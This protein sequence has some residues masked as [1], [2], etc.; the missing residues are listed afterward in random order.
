MRYVCSLLS[1]FLIANSVAQDVATDPPGT[2]LIED[3]S[4]FVETTFD[5]NSRTPHPTLTASGGTVTSFANAKE[6]GD[7]SQKVTVSAEIPKAGWYQV[8]MRWTTFLNTVAQ[9]ATNVPVTI[10][11]K[12]GPFDF[13][14]N[15]QS[16]NKWALLGTYEFAAGTQPVISFSN[17][18]TLQGANWDAV[19]LIP[20]D[21][22]PSPR[23]A[24]EL[25]KT[26]DGFGR[27]KENIKAFQIAQLFGR[28]DQET[29]PDAVQMAARNE[30]RARLFWD[31]MLDTPTEK[32]N[33]NWMQTSNSASA[34]R[35][36]EA[37]LLREMAVAYVGASNHLGMDLRGNPE[38]L[39]AIIRG[40]E[41]FSKRYNVETKWDVNWWDYEI[42]VPLNLLPAL[43]VLGDAVPTDLRDGFI[44]AS[45]RF[46]SDPRK[47]YNNA[48]PATGAN[49]LWLCNVA[50][51]RGALAEDAGLLELVKESVLEP[52]EFVVRDFDQK[53]K[54][55]SDGFYEDGSFIQ[56][57]G[58][59]YAAA[60]GYLLLES[61]AEVAEGLQNTPWALTGPATENAFR[62]MEICFDPFVVRGETVQ[63][64]VGR[65]LG[66]PN[67]EGNAN[68]ANF[69][70]TA[71]KLLPFANPEQAARLRSLIKKWV[72]E[73]KDGALLEYARTK[74]D[75]ANPVSA[76]VLA[77][78]VK[79]PAIK[80]LPPG[81]G[82]Q[83]FANMDIATHRTG[84]FA[85]SLGMNS[86]RTQ[87][88][89][90]IWGANAKGWFQSE[91]LFLLYSPDIERYRD[92]YFNLVDPYRFP[93]V[94]VE[95]FERKPGDGGG[96]NPGKPGGGDFVGGVG[97]NGNGIAAMHLK[98][99]EGALEARRAWFFFGDQIICLGA[100]IG[101]ASENLI[102]TTIENARLISE[103]QQLVI[104]SQ[105]VAEGPAKIWPGA[106]WA[107]L[108]GSR[109]GADLGWVFLDGNPPLHSLIETRNGSR[110]DTHIKTGD[111]TPRS[112]RFATLWLDHGKGQN[113]SG[114]A[115]VVLPGRTQQQLQAYA[116]KP[117][118]SILSNTASAQSV[119]DPAL[120]LTGIVAWSPGEIS[121]VSLDQP[122]LVLIQD[123]GKE[124]SVAVS[125]PTMRLKDPVTIK[126]PHRV[127]SAT[128]TD[129]RIKVVSLAPLTLEFQPDGANG[130]THRVS[131][132]K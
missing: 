1:F 66:S 27:L 44:A 111:P 97:L 4:T 132:S 40:L 92:A 99:A 85:V 109:P 70:V 56:H 14:I 125:D 67:Y 94:T 79:D 2:I 98:P 71:S 64:V 108:G 90:T 19:K 8:W 122:A 11:S 50:M 59:P 120:G 53:K 100:G 55:G 33:S 115:Y 13:Q 57:G 117:P 68:A 29:D 127:K 77:E 105:P 7:G 102:E 86:K 52:L 89:E 31:L 83:M 124:L 106:K 119:S 113:N 118:V 17:N 65:S 63:N 26:P 54:G 3:D 32:T 96:A 130:Q 110:R 73:E 74:A 34:F 42:G 9:H 39:K 103:T 128:L 129:D 20:L 121:G 76:A 12:A 126:L 112:M 46:N 43:V 91:G 87:T 51:F 16:G 123:S 101:A 58:I 18:G 78:I 131:F 23:P 35:T 88:F 45:N 62:I 25:K 21:G 104:D 82:F 84:D 47:F 116:A 49:R 80:P 37:G 10:F 48:F 61:Y 69:V 60:Y 72:T 28:G 41:N 30:L 15:Q 36:R 24:P 75:A 93:G 38:L 6:T 5:A 81:Q 95:R 107:W 22:K 114:Y